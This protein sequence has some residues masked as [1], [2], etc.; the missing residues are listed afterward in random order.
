MASDFCDF[1]SK[2]NMTNAI[3]RASVGEVANGT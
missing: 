3:A 1:F 2:N